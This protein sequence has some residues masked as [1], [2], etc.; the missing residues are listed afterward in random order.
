[1]AIKYIQSI[2]RCRPNVTLALLD[3]R[4]ADGYSVLLTTAAAGFITRS[5]K[6]TRTLEPP[7]GVKAPPGALLVLYIKYVAALPSAT[8][9]LRLPGAT[10]PSGIGRYPG[11]VLTDVLPFLD[12]MFGEHSPPFPRGIAYLQV[13]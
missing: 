12:G 9:V 1:M 10:V 7:G 6:T 5:Y 11:L 4:P 8:T 2:R 13:V 3:P